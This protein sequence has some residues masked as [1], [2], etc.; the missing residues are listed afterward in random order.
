VLLDAIE[1]G[2]VERAAV[3]GALFEFATTDGIIAPEFEITERGDPTVGPITVYVAGATFETHEVVTPEP[4]LV[5]A[6]KGS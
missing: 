6:A 5:E 2:G 3:T 1:R 4:D